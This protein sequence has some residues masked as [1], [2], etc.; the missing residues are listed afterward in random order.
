MRL[1][2]EGYPQ[3]FSF[4]LIEILDEKETRT[5]IPGLVIRSVIFLLV[6]RLFRAPHHTAPFSH[7]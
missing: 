7:Y 5:R 2:L 3:I 1:H 4:K 6:A